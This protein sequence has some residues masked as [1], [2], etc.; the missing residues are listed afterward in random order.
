MTAVAI[1]VRLDTIVPIR[2]W[3]GSGDK[4]VPAD[5]IETDSSAFYLGAGELVG[6]PV[7]QQLINGV[8]ERAMFT[9]AGGSV[10]SQ[11]VHLADRDAS[12]VRY[13]EGHVGVRECGRDGQPIGPVDWL[14]HGLADS[15]LIDEPPALAGQATR[16]IG[17]SMAGIFTLRQRTR[18]GFY[19]GIDQRGR[20]ADDASCD[21]VPGYSQGTTKDWGPV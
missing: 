7:L 5:T 8:E 9:L 14:W 20:S 18:P 3:F 12:T 10:T 2:L 4:R 21:L 17:V 19:T 13:A 16:T 6:V 1:F 11:V 15:V